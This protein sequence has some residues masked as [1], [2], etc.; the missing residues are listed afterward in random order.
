MRKVLILMLVFAAFGF[1]AQAN[2]EGDVLLASPYKVNTMAAVAAGIEGFDVGAKASSEVI[3]DLW[4]GSDF[5]Q[6]GNKEVMLASYGT[7]GKAYVYEIDG[8]NTAT[9]FFETPDMGG[10]YTT[11][12]RH[13]A[14]GDLD[15]NGMQEL[16]VSVN[17]TS[18]ATG[19]LWAFEY[20]TV[21]D[22]MRAPVQ[23]FKA[24]VTANRWYCENFTVGD[25]DKDGV[26]EIIFG[27]NGSLNAYDKF[28]IA[29]V[30]T[31]TSFADNNITTTIEFEHG[32]YG[33][34]PIGGS[35]Y[36]GVIADLNGDGMNEVL[37]APWDHGAMLI[38]END[39]ADSYTAV[40][41]IQT[42]LDRLDDF[43]FWDFMVNDLDGDG[44]DEAY[45][46]MYDGGRLYVTTCPEDTA[47]ADLTT[48]DVHTIDNLG[49]SGGVA[50]QMGDLDG[51]G[52]MNIYASGGGSYLTNH[53]FIGTD[54]TDSTH[55]MK[56]DNITSPS[57]KG[58]Y[59][60]RYAG[61][62][63]GD[64]YD[65]IYGANT[66]AT[67]VACVGVE[68]MPVDVPAV[69]F[70][71]YI[72]G[73]GNNKA[74]EIY[75]GTDAEISL[76]DYRIAQTNNGSEWKYW[77][78]FP[79]GATLAAGDVWVL[80]NEDADS[81]LVDFLE[82][83]EVLGYPSA[84]HHNGDDARAVEYTP[85]GGTTWHKTDVIGF[86]F[87]D[88]GSAWDVAG[89]EKGT[90]DHSLMRKRSVVKG[91]LNW[92]DA[93]GTTTS[94]SE[95]EVFAK[96][97][98][99]YL[100]E[101]P[102]NDF[103]D[104]F[105]DGNHVYRWTS[106][107]SGWTSRVW[108]D[109]DTCL[110]LS[111]GG[112]TI[113]AR[114]P[115]YATPGTMFKVTARIQSSGFADDPTKYLNLGVDGL[116]DS[117]FEVS[118]ISDTAFVTFTVIGYAE[119]ETGTL[120]FNGQ[121]KGG[122]ATVLIDEFSF[123]DN[124]VNTSLSTV[125]DARGVA[126]GYMVLVKGIATTTTEYGSAG[127]VY[128]QDETAG[129]AVYDY[130]TAQNVAVGDE[131]VVYGEIDIYGGLIEVTNVEYAVLSTGN[132]VE[133]VE[134]RA[135]DLDGEAYEGQLVVVK[136][137]DSLDT[138]LGWPETAGSNKGFDLIDKYGD[139][140]YCY[141][142]KDTDID[143]TPTPEIWPINITG[144]VGDYYGAQILP[145]SLED[146]DPNTP[147][148][149]FSIVN[150][151][152]GTTYA[153]LDDPGF[154]DMPMGEGG[155]SVKTF[156]ANWTSS[157]DTI[158]PGDSVT[159]QIMF[160]SDGPEDEMI[161][162]DT[163]MYIPIDEYTP[164]EMNGTYSVYVKATDESNDFT[165][166]DTVTFTFDFPAPPVLVNADV[167]LVDGVPT[168]YVEFDLPLDAPAIANFS[169]LDLSA[170]GVITP[171]AVDLIAPNAVMISAPFVEDSR[172][173]LVCSGLTT[174]GATIS[175]TDTTKDQTVYIPFSD[176]HP[177]DA[178]LLIEGFEGTLSYFTNLPTYSGST[179]GILATS[180][181]VASADEAY[182]GTKS[183]KLTLLDDPAVDGGW[184]VR[185]YVKYP[186]SKTVNANSTIFLMV[187]GTGKV[188][189]ALT[190]KDDG[191]E[192]NMWKSVSLCAT[193]WQVVS[194]DISNDEIEGWATGNGVLT[195]ET[196][197]IC[198]LHLQSSVDEDVVLYIDG[199][200][201]RKVLSPVDITLNVIMKK[202]FADGAFNLLD[203]VD[204]A[205]S[206]N[207]W[208]GSGDIMTDYDSDTTYSITV[209]MIP[210]GTENFKFRINGS[211]DTSEFP[212]GGPNRVLVVPTV[213]AEY[214]YW[215]NDDTLEVAIDGVPVEFALHQNYPN[216]FNPVTTIS[217]DLPSI[218]DVSLVI[219]D[220]TGR[221]VRTLISN[222]N[223][224][225]GY[226]KI[227]WNGRDDF[228]NG[229]ATG[230]YIYRLIAGD[231][232]DVKK[233]TFLK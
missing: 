104:D 81:S 186:Y 147:P 21:G 165:N 203:Y 48:A 139:T 151:I 23:L 46:S 43:A 53:E 96:N 51:N 91:N 166:S 108:A 233:M 115:V 60:M 94:N 157:I 129:I 169:I 55:W 84:V 106:A 185:E 225:A 134:V 105:S 160:A 227:V 78:T 102:P 42:D 189:I 224:D 70:S 119:N 127:P 176:A 214:T 217:F 83:D 133:P 112:W 121:S 73:S 117:D 41:Y 69:F 101:F 196:V 14:Y 82:A 28:Y 193:D 206:F 191:Y 125:A 122:A 20:D 114:L 7:S 90:Q 71:E 135:S 22:S 199:L 54:P 170:P 130:N 188:D 208:D 45:V 76:D 152:D 212:S 64:G 118:C 140:L 56:L 146:F 215:Y 192:R 138:G 145:R 120:Y 159:Y 194:F 49:T 8:D 66:G 11:A 113:D 6:D 231:F 89:I 124:Y 44:R 163:F 210:Y 109:G 223:I 95:W 142:D 181:L 18:D 31:G 111:D 137:C 168:Y 174:P 182:E 98:M 132:I 200:T 17:S 13:V 58:V 9:L 52:R 37:F 180:S 24:L 209:P 16:L 171:T 226:K 183:G 80:L 40:N 35:P 59:G 211:W 39:S 173:A 27:N 213:A 128:I 126:E 62:F 177:E 158:P 88:P 222:S 74:I 86:P 156:L 75:N 99:I 201:E 155:D 219:Y 123:D 218:T 2:L 179:N 107:N 32:R 175:I 178:G 148:G 3:R 228:G 97:T 172:V 143:G 67:T 85:D 34:F 161:T 68:D 195:G 162:Q 204:V 12:T 141:I 29:Q 93:A 5:D 153:S 187:K 205:G 25:V 38:V 230:M 36:G 110:T 15:G 136:G 131:L 216:P 65:E 221:K 19:G 232:V 26:E 144:I 57:F 220:I 63:D 164:Y 103:M 202:Q 149:E 116:A 61:D 198:D 207:G 79:T 50:T 154:Y 197:T 229:V 10:S 100:G 47:L 1:A 190:V 77:H 33:T 92:A 150:P 72:E 87:Y 167:V 4:V 30:D 184:F